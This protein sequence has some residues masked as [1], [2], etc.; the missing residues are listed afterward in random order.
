MMFRPIPLP[1]ATRRASCDDVNAMTNETPNQARPKTKLA[2]IEMDFPYITTFMAAEMLRMKQKGVEIIIL[3]INR[4]SLKNIQAVYARLIDSVHFSSFLD[5][6]TIKA[7]A[8][9]LSHKPRHLVAA[10]GEV[11]LSIRRPLKYVLQTWAI[12]PMAVYCAWFVERNRVDHVHANWA[13]YPATIAMIIKRLTGVPFSFSSHAGADLF[14]NPDLLERK[15]ESASFSFTCV[16]SN[17]QFLEQI[18]G[19]A[20]DGQVHVVYHGVDLGRFEYRGED[21]TRIMAP[22]YRFLSV[23]NLH[24]PKGFQYMIAAC[25]ALKAQGIPFVYHIVGSGYDRLFLEQK[26]RDAG[27]QDCAHLQGQLL[28]PDLLKLYQAADVFI[29]PSIVLNNGGRDGIPNVVIEAMATGIPVVGSNAAGIPEVVKNRSTGLLV[30]P[31]DPEALA[32][33]I[34]GLLDNTALRIKIVS[35]ARRLVETSFDQDRN[36]EILYRVFQQKVFDAHPN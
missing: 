26:I 32:T 14:R 27:V 24:R 20:L 34:R 13:H 12:L 28:H 33:A 15:L 21:P 5:L 11:L 9:Y 2:Y 17:K 19:H 30:P 23:G 22:P 3:P 8:Y 1:E 6:R 10:I 35:N 29:M 18:A 31:G 36:F 25:R 7:W 4:R 16:Q